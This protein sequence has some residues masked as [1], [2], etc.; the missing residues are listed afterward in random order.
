MVVKVS[1]ASGASDKPLLGMSSAEKFDDTVAQH[2]N[3]EAVVCLH[4]DLRLTYSELAERVNTL[5]KALIAWGFNKGDR[6]GIW[7]PNNVDWLTTQY[8]TA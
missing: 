7:S 4:Q 3:R 8:A 1:Y 2:G 6:I 5:A